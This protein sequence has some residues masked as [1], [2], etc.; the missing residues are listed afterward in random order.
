MRTVVVVMTLVLLVLPASAQVGTKPG[1]LQN[2][3]QKQTDKPKI[4]D[5]DYRNALGN[6]P[7]KKFDPWKDMR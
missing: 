5:K 3:N 6:L 7:D 4:N 1:T 2:G